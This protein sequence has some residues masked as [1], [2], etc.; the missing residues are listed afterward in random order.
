MIPLWSDKR[1]RKKNGFYTNFKHIAFLKKMNQNTNTQNE[2]HT[3]FASK[4]LTEKYSEKKLIS[5]QNI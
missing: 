2:L 3:K 4:R 5:N 1:E